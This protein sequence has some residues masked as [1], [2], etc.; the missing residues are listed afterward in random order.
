MG[1]Y[2][3]KKEEN[4]QNEFVGIDFISILYLELAHEIADIDEGGV[5]QF[6]FGEEGAAFEVVLIE[7]GEGFVYF[8]A[9]VDFEE[10]DHFWYADALV[11][12]VG[13]DLLEKYLVDIN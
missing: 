1:Q 8:H 13:G 7:F 4:E 11:G 3:Q 9:I 5:P 6:F 10:A 2:L 12:G